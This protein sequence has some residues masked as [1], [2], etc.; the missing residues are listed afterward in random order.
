MTE[1]IKIKQENN[2][3]LVDGRDLHTF[4][5]SKQEF[6]NWIKAR[7]EKY[8][9][10]EGE[11]FLTILSKSTGGRPTIEFAIVLDAA[12][13][14]AMVEGNEKGKQ[15][16]RYFIDCEKKLNNAS[17][18]E[19]QAP[20]RLGMHPDFKKCMYHLR[21]VLIEI[22]TSYEDNYKKFEGH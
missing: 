17:I 19:Y 18:T 4:L 3:K 9:L 1:L 7:I 21:K 6:S 16:R 2:K 15:A 14:L 20:Q 22:N 8:G 10:K 5:E 13:E 12:K 11:D